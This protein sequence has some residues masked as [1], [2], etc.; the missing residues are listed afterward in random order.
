MLTQSFTVQAETIDK[1]EGKET[2]HFPPT[3]HLF[4]LIKIWGTYSI[5][6]I[7]YL[8][9]PNSSQ[10]N[11][12]FSIYPFSFSFYTLHLNHNCKYCISTIYHLLYVICIYFCIEFCKKPCR[13]TFLMQVFAGLCT[14]CKVT[15]SDWML[16]NT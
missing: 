8:G 3:L 4:R 7:S 16:Q 15:L 2:K 12:L 13:I 11:C 1:A 10:S 5:S 9:V 6:F 14:T